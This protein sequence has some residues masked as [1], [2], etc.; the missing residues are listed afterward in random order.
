MDAYEYARKWVIYEA[1]EK[2]KLNFRSPEEMRRLGI[3]S[4]IDMESPESIY[5]SLKDYVTEEQIEITLWLIF[6]NGK[7]AGMVEG[8]SGE[9]GR[10]HLSIDL[11]H[12]TV[13]MN[14]E[15]F[16]RLLLENSAVVQ[17]VVKPGKGETDKMYF[18]TP[19]EI[20]KRGI[21]LPIRFPSPESVYTSFLKLTK[22]LK[23]EYSWVF[24]GHRVN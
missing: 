1:L 12:P 7:I 16:S 24:P 13:V 22:K 6:K 17:E 18:L 14:G 5:K 4:S 21:E 23:V 19:K 2:G 20:K 11:T 8:T 9:A 3:P 15:E 10:V